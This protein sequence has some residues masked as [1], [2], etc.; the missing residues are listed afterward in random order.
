MQG[1]AEAGHLVTTTFD[2]NGDGRPDSVTHLVH[3]VAS[4]VDIYDEVGLRIVA[5]QHIEGGWHDFTD[6]DG[7]GDGTFERRVTYDRYGEPKSN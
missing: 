6:F 4:S 1:L 2:S 5:R 7:D 3:G